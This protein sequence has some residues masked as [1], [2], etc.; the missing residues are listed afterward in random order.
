MQSQNE[1]I[2]PLVALPSAWS[3]GSFSGI[4]ARGNFSLGI[5][6]SD[7]KADKITVKSN[8]GN[9]CG[10]KY[11]NI[12]ECFVTDITE[13]KLVSP[14]VVDKDTI[15]FPTV[16]G[17]TYVIS[18]TSLV[19]AVPT[20]NSPTQSPAATP[21]QDN[22]DQNAVT[23]LAQNNNENTAQVNRVKLAKP[24]IK[25]VKCKNK[26]LNIVL[27]KKVSATTGYTVKYSLKKNMKS[28]VKFTVKS[29]KLKKG[30]IITKVLK[31]LKKGKKYYVQVNAYKKVNK[32]KYYSKWSAKKKVI[33][34]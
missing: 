8:S 22:Q 19:V 17:N 14:T 7:E 21:G 28:S 23:T 31:K 11:N 25:S 4:K 33:V 32:V 2:E 16:E 12:S 20:Q 5:D 30:K 13:N 10:I 1:Y 26:K 27:K 24:V 9:D 6:W 15:K 29:S 18:K 3:E 34:K